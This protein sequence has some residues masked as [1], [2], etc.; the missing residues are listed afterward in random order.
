MLPSVRAFGGLWP[1][2]CWILRLEKCKTNQNCMITMGTHRAYFDLFPSFK[3]PHVAPCTFN[4][5]LVPCMHAYALSSLS[6]SIVL[7]KWNFIYNSKLR[8]RTICSDPSN[9]TISLKIWMTTV[10]AWRIRACSISVI[11]AYIHMLHGKLMI[12][13]R[14]IFWWPI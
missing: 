13:I 5:C 8:Q 7:L 14:W 10:H 2:H 6:R 3:G 9:T 12:L 4:P 1:S 11:P